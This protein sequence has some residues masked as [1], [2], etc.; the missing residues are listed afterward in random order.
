MPTESLER[1]FTV[2]APGL[3]TGQVATILERAIR[4][5]VHQERDARHIGLGPLYGEVRGTA[6]HATIGPW[7]WSI[8]RGGML[9]TTVDMQVVLDGVIRPTPD[10][11]EIAIVARPERTWP[12][13]ALALVFTGALAA[14]M[15]AAVPAPA[16]ALLFAPLM[17][18]APPAILAVMLR[19]GRD[20]SLERLPQVAAF[21]GVLLRAG[22][23]PGW[24]DP[25][26]PPD[27]TGAV[28]P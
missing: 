19:R 21:I 23:G 4:D 3:T 28:R 25:A 9:T 5:G 2:P 15:L 16:T 1:A 24:R 17:W 10:G 18:L 12:M 14:A 6:V 8:G 27:P 11:A 20:R 26:M 22:T 13:L 7:Y